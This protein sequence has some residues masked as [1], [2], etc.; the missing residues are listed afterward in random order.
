MVREGERKSHVGRFGPT[1]MTEA[2]PAVAALAVV[3]TSNYRK[4]SD[5][6]GIR[7]NPQRYVR[8]GGRPPLDVR[9]PVEWWAPRNRPAANF[10][11][12]GVRGV[13]SYFRAGDP[14]PPSRI[15]ESRQRG[16]T[17]DIS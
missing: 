3:E 14:P 4:V 16:T 5:R 15:I 6:G 17:V 11:S 12:N 7:M 13:L 8:L 2:R 10:T 1:M 9:W